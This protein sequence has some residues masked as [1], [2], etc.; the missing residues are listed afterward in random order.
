MKNEKCK[1]KK[2]STAEVRC[3][4]RYM[5]VGVCIFSCLPNQPPP[6]KLLNSPS[7]CRIRA[8]ICC[9]S[10]SERGLVTRESEQ[11]LGRGRNVIKLCNGVRN[12]GIPSCCPILHVSPFTSAV[13]YNVKCKDILKRLEGIYSDL[14]L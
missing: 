10:G 6:K 8:V 12:E 5:C 7:Q 3:S 13:D 1:Q 9:V 11:K 2:I 14:K 4:S